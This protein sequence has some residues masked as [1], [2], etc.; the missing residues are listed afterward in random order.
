MKCPYCGKAVREDMP[1][2]LRENQK[3]L[4]KHRH[5]LTQS[6]RGSIEQQR[7]NSDVKSGYRGQDN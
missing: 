6:L 3:C 2:H 4:D 7:G 5:V 1:K